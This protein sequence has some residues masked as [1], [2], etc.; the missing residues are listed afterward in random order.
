MAFF[1]LSVCGL[2]AGLRVGLLSSAGGIAVTILL[3]GLFVPAIMISFMSR[4]LSGFKNFI[5]TRISCV[6]DLVRYVVTSDRIDWSREDVARAVHEIVD[7]VLAPGP[8]YREDADL[9]RDLGLS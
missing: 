5:P 1:S 9:V 2:A 7:D 8:K 4:L 6:R 3:L